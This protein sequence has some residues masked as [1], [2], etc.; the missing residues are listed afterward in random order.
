MGRQLKRGFTIIELMIIIVVIS[1]L[2]SI[3]Y[4]VYD[5]WR[6]RAAETQVNNELTQAA[7]SLKQASNFG[8]SYPATADFSKVYQ[9][10][11]EVNLDY[12]LRPDGTYCLNGSSQ[13]VSSVEYSV[14]SRN[15][16]SPQSGSCTP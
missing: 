3:T 16:S 11:P 5:S 6:Q 15:G 13:T 12:Q 7:S 2:V 1:I 14:D 9:P 8:S 4:L 10:G